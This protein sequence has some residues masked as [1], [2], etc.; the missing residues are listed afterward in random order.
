M[1]S[2]N[3]YRLPVRRSGD[4]RT[5]AYP[6]GSENGPTQMALP[7]AVPHLLVFTQTTDFNVAGLFE[8]FSRA[9]N[10]SVLVDMRI[11]PRLEFIGA[12]RS[13]TFDYFKSMQIDYK[14]VFG[15]VGITS[16]ADAE[17]KHV[18]ISKAVAEILERAKPSDCSVLFFFDDPG[19]MSRC[20]RIFDP[21]FE[22]IDLDSQAIH[23]K[24]AESTLLQM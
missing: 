10:P 16:Y 7:F 9:L 23:R 20:R 18:A 4:V 17:E 8:Q 1:G 5:P 21:V 24:A 14:D 2:D 22:I 3:V 13:Q 19:F 11:S 6:V 12:T 15:K